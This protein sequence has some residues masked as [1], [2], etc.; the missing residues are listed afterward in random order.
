MITA[1][2]NTAGIFLA[3]VMEESGWS[4]TGASLYMTIFAWIAAALQPVVGRVFE[5]FD[6]RWVMTAVVVVFCASYL[7]S[8]T[9][10]QLWQWNVFGVLYGV[11]AAFFMYLIQPVLMT[12]WFHTRLGLAMSL[13]GVITGI[14]GFGVNP[15]I[16]SMIDGGGWRHARLWT[17]LVSVAVCL[18]LTILFVRHSPERLGQRPHGVPL[19]ATSAD[20]GTDAAPTPAAPAAVGVTLSRAIRTVPFYLLLVFALISV[21]IPSLIQQLPS[22]AAAAPIG[23]MAGA[24]AISLFSVFGLV[25]NPFVGWFFDAVKSKIGNG[26]CYALTIVGLVLMIAGRGESAVLFYAGVLC[27]TFSF[28]PLTMGTPLLVR[29][30][31][32]QRDFSAIYSWVTAVVLVS[33]GIAPLV[34]AQVYDRT[35]SYAPMLVL[36]LVLSVVQLAFIPVIAALTSKVDAARTPQ[37]VAA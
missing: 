26:V 13:V 23:A 30:V 1:M 6:V 10:T 11:T 8:A 18:P 27:W 12:R 34:Y 15:W 14:V 4:R 21:I 17:G 16:Q 20:D 36:A 5:R 25:R 33:G 19:D 9:Y 29:E 31:F 7:W 35:G 22:Y 37:A 24:F 28:I 3:P 2:C 32:G